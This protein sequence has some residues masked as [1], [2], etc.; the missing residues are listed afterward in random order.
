MTCLTAHLL[1]TSRCFDVVSIRRFPWD[2]LQ[3]WIERYLREEGALFKAR[4]DEARRIVDSLSAAVEA[5]HRDT[6]EY[7]RGIEDLVRRPERLSAS[8]GNWPYARET[9]RDPWGQLYR[10]ACP[11]RFNPQGFDV[12]SVHGNSRLP[13]VWI[14]NWKDQATAR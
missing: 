6:L 1:L 11:G 9:P 14:G 7:P 13:A 2:D 8:K 4:V 12:Y 5:Y 10:Y 3:G